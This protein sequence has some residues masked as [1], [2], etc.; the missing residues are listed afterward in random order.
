MRVPLTLIDF[1]ER[2]ALHEDRV[3]VVDEPD[4]PASLGAVTHADLARRS[5]GMA[6]ALDRMGVGHGARVAIV[7]PNSA[8]FVIALFGVSAF[9]RVLVPINFRLAAQEIDYIVRHAGAEVVLI[10]PELGDARA[11][12]NAPHKILLDGIA[13]AELF[14][15]TD[16][17][18]SYWDP[19]ED[20]TASINYTSGT[21]GRPK[22]VQ[23]THRTLWLHAVSVGW[24]LGVSP[25]DVYLQAQPLFHCNGWGLPYGL[26]AMGARQVI[27]RRVDGPELLRRVDTQGVTL[28]CGAPAVVDAALL[29][30]PAYAGAESVPGSGRMRIFIGGAPPPPTTIQRVADE[31]GWDFIHGY[32]LTESSPVLTI[33]HAPP[34]DDALP[35]A[36]RAQRLGRQGLP[37]IGVRLRIDDHDEILARSN[38]VTAGYWDDPEATDGAITDG[39]LHTGDE[40]VIDGE[41]Y[42]RITDRKKDVIVSGG[43]N[44]SS[45]EVEDCLYT[46][47][48][49]REVAVIGVPDTRWGETVKALVVLREGSNLDGAAL[50]AFA[51]ERLAHFKCPTSVELRATLPHTASGKIQKFALRAPYWD[52]GQ[53]DAHS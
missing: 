18:P 11:G 20:A 33:N 16:S 38:H 45:I 7:S 49:V 2:G 43:E 31:L 44:I 28:S 23:L 40:G 6:L 46:H 17:A 53:P 27:L 12:V 35:A 37:V 1:L 25:R 51:R 50:I 42:L 32:G 14:A 4:G 8:R 9:G 26:T 52:G 22:G 24:H 36:A 47:P 39:W 30:A 10:D 5:R 13:D 41:H 29:A 15:P 48:D 34:E 21:T 19:D 3:A